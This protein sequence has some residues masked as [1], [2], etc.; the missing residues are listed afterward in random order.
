MPRRKNQYTTDRNA[1]IVSLYDGVTKVPMRTLSD[2]YGVSRVQ[3]RKILEAAGCTIRP[4]VRE[5]D[6][7]RRPLTGNHASIGA[8]LYNDRM[9][10]GMSLGEYGLFVGMSEQRVAQIHKGIYDLTVS[11]II[12]ISERTGIELQTLIQPTGVH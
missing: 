1:E 8:R 2:D 6:G 7:E 3:I 9:T 11:E 4:E 12:R 10:R 5:S